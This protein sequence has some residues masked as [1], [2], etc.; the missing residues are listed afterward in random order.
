MSFFVQFIPSIIYIDREGE[1]ERVVY[2]FFCSIRTVTDIRTQDLLHSLPISFKQ[3]KQCLPTST[4][5]NFCIFP[6]LLIPAGCSL[7]STL[8]PFS[9]HELYFLLP[10]V[11]N[12]PFQFHLG[13][14]NETSVSFSHWNISI[15]LRCK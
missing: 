2:V 3:S 5:V 13:S 4:A 9:D 8:L 14:V 10:V 15:V 7:Y 6:P 12:C 1:R 11:Q